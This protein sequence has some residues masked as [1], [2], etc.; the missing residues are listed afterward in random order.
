MKASCDSS[1]VSVIIPNFN[2]ADFVGEAIQ[3]VL[4]Q[5]YQNTEIIVVNNGSTDNSL[6]I[7]RSF[8]DKILIVDQ[9]NLGQSGARNAG[10]AK[11]T[12]EL[13][14]FLDADDL[15]EPKKLEKQMIL[16]QSDTH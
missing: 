16:L 9:A 14:A 1:K 5:T 15:W 8:G 7:L 10:L 13:I 3:S 2:Y 4:K 11:S 12:G 6:E